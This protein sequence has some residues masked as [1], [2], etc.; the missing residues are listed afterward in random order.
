M[1]SII[2]DKYKGKKFA[3]DWLALL[4]DANA[5]KT[6]TV[7]VYKEDPADAEK[8]IQVEE[9][10]PGGVDV[11]KLLALANEN[12]IDTANLEKAKDGHGFAGRA[13][14]T[15]RNQMQTVAKQRHGLMINGEFVS[16]PIDWLAEKQAPE[17]P[18]HE[19][20]GTKIAKA[21]EPAKEAEDA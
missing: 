8:K 12:G 3:K 18:T 14:M 9:E 11:D 21:V 5:S 6:R 17:S 15:L 13:R 7:K 1:G 20:D 4:L 2:S 10:R 19:Q 16:A